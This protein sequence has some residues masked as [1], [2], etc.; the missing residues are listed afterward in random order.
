MHSRPS[1]PRASHQ[2]L[3]SARAQSPK[4]ASSASGRVT[5][6]CTPSRQSLHKPLTSHN[7][8][9]RDSDG[10]FEG[11][12]QRGGRPDLERNQHDGALSRETPPHIAPS[13]PNLEESAASVP[14]PLGP[15]GPSSLLTP[16]VIHPLTPVELRVQRRRDRLI[17][18]RA[19]VLIDQCG[20]WRVMAH[21]YHQIAQA[22]P[23]TVPPTCFP[24]AVGRAGEDRAHLVAP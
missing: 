11:A 13:Q 23:P 6:H 10:L 22:R 19:A 7:T 4:R 20:G 1:R 9:G 21:P 5:G 8:A 18:R 12:D 2:S 17:R 3:A 14:P 15:H 24:Y 16:A